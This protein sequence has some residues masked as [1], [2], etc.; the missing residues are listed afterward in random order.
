MNPISAAD[1]FLTIAIMTVAFLTEIALF[2]L[3]GMI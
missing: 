2:I 1:V 3:V